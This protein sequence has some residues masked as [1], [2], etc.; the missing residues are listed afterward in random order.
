MWKRAFDTAAKCIAETKEYNKK[1]YYKTHMEPDFIEGDQVL[2]STL[3]FNNLKEPKKMRDLFVGPFTIV[4]LIGENAVEVRLTEEFSRKNPAFP[5][6]LVKPY[7]QTGEDM[8]PSMNKT[9]T[10]QDIVEVEESPGC[11]KKIRDT[12]WSDSRAKEQIR[13]NGWQKMP[14]QMVNFT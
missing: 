2:L 12:I 8:F 13:I 1:M 14:Y 7:F 5:M 11:V 6:S 10:P 3:N 9:S 4:K